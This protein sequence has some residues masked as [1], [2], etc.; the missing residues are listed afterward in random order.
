MGD[1]R[2]TLRNGPTQV[3]HPGD[4]VCV[5]RGTHLE[6]LLGSCVSVILTDRARTIAAMCHI[7]YPRTPVAHPQN[8][9]YGAP[10]ALDR[11]YELL[12]A[13]GMTP[14]LCEAW[15]YG[16][17]DMF[18]RVFKHTH[19][20]FRN[21]QAVLQRLDADNIRVIQQDLGG[22]S[23]RSLKWTVGLGLPAVTATAV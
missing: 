17:G 19:V 16:A 18:P 20:G 7:V 10:G 9:T 6:T 12:N 11:M 14:T 8:T 2:P 5:D 23:Y 21:A 4:V 15:V 22:R 3:L 13:R 1:S